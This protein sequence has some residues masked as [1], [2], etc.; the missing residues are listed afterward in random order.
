MRIRRYA[1]AALA[2]MMSLS[3]LGVNAFAETEELSSEAETLEEELEL[4]TLGGETVYPVTITDSLGNETVLEEEPQV[5]VSLGPTITELMFALGAGDKLAAR[6]EYCDYPEEAFALPT[7]GN[8]YDVDVEAVLALEPDLVLSSVHVSEETLQQF[9][10]AGISTIYL[11]E[12]GSLEGVYHF[13]ATMGTAINRQEEALKLIDG[14]KATIEGVE[15]ALDGTEPVSVYYVIGYGEYG[16]YTAG[17]D[18]YAND[19]LEKAG[20]ANIAADVEGWSY[21]T[22]T[23]LEK[24]PEWIIVPAWSYDDFIAM[25][26]YS[27]LTAVKEGRVYAIDNNKLDRQT[28]RNAEAILE[29]AEVLHPEA[30]EALQALEPETEEDAE[31]ELTTEEASEEEPA[32]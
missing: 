14:M 13:I 20:G 15:E 26:P 22:E 7:I 6:T 31:A 5:V 8:M 10:D 2:A 9:T 3:V 16:D 19:I 21:S 17:G 18:T 1:A 24:D 29:L 30:L 11:F 12:E 23:L 4:I 32:A 28:N 25:E 27:E